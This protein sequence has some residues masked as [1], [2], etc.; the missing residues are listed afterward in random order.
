MPAPSR[1]PRYTLA[2]WL[3]LSRGRGGG[4]WVQSVLVIALFCLGMPTASAIGA[5]TRSGVGWIK[6]IS[7]YLAGVAVAIGVAV[8][9]QRRA[10]R[11]QPPAVDQTEG[12]PE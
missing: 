11:R 8:W 12:R 3:G 2:E 10:S 4:D 7:I 1:R 9:R 5:N 6:L